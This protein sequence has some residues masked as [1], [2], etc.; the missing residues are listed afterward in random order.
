MRRDLF[1]ALISLKPIKRLAV[2]APPPALHFGVTISVDSGITPCYSEH[3]CDH[4]TL[5]PSYA[6]S[7]SDRPIRARIGCWEVLPEHI[8]L[9]QTHACGAD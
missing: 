4:T 5:E 9:G 2:V 1:G 7:G 8:G 3:L 6:I